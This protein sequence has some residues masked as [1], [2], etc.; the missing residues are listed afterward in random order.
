MEYLDRMTG[1][2]EVAGAGKMLGVV[3]GKIVVGSVAGEAGRRGC[4]IEVADGLVLDSR[5]NFLE[6]G[7]GRVPGRMG[8]GADLGRF[9]TGCGFG[10]FGSYG[11]AAD[12]VGRPKG[13][14]RGD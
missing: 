4:G 12:F 6:V 1:A 7:S 5:V 3:V 2:E 13:C 11:L 8:H 9:G 14:R 10:C